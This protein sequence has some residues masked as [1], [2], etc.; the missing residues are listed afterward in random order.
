[1]LTPL[2]FDKAIAEGNDP[3]ADTVT[4]ANDQVSKKLIKVLIYNEQTITPIT[5]NLQTVAKSLNIPIVPIT[6]TMPH[7]KTYQTWMMDQLN[8]LQQALATATGK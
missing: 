2:E 3:P 7:G 1:V 6:E 4:T 5:T 8:T